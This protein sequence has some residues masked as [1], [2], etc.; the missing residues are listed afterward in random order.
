[1]GDEYRRHAQI[2]ALYNTP[3]EIGQTDG[4][5]QQLSG[6][7][8]RGSTDIMISQSSSFRVYV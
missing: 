4:P 1:M 3:L 5:Y 7:N 8:R 2:L 6:S